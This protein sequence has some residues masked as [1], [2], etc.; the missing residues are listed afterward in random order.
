[1]GLYRDNGKENG[2]YYIKIGYMLRLYLVTFSFQRCENLPDHCIVISLAIRSAKAVCS[3]TYLIANYSLYP[4]FGRCL[5]LG[6]ACSKHKARYPRKG[7]G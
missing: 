2:S 5:T 6:I 1:M 3:L 7:V 4:F